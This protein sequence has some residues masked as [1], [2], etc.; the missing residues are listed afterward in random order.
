LIDGNLHGYPP[1]VVRWLQNAI[2]VRRMP[3][4]RAMRY[5]GREGFT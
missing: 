1:R 3:E 4:E 2:N 5:N